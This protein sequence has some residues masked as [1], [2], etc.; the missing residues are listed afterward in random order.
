MIFLFTRTTF[1]LRRRR[2]RRL[3]LVRPTLY[4]ITL[5]WM[6][7]ATLNAVIIMVYVRYTLA[8]ATPNIEANIVL[9]LAYVRTTQH[10]E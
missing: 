3:A 7:S 1:S 5:L 2:R 6:L 8:Q 9:W 10:N 4:S